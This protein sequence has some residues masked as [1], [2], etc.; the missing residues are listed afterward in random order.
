MEKTK[1]NRRFEAAKQMTHP[2]FSSGYSTNVCS[3]LNSFL[4]DLFKQE[5][6]KAFQ[7]FAVKHQ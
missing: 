4:G 6:D 2:I 1:D 7:S 3:V 5:A